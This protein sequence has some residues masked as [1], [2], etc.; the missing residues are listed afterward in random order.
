MNA[1][2]NYD[3]NLT[4]KVKINENKFDS[5]IPGN[6]K[7]DY[8]VTDSNGNTTS[9]EKEIDIIKT[10]GKGESFILNEYKLKLNSFW[11]SKRDSEPVEGYYSYYN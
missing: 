2:D 5:N 3:G 7:I 10:Y 4:E 11:F 1:T 6:Y 8:T 9:K